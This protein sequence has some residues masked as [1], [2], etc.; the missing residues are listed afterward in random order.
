MGGIFKDPDFITKLAKNPKTAPFLAD[1]EFMEKLN[2]IRQNPNLLQTEL[3]DPRIMQV[4]AALLG[5]QMEMGDPGNSGPGGSGAGGSRF[6]EDTEMPDADPQPKKSSPEPPK[7]PEPADEEAKAKREAKEAADREKALGTENYKKRQFD[8]AIEHYSKA[9]E[10][11]KDITYL[12][13]LAAA[14]F[15]SGDYEGCIQECERAIEEGRE[16]RADF[17]LIA[18]YPSLPPPL[19]ISQPQLT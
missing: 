16:I 10:L 17:K 5:I 2:K 18:K 6:D 9:W 11:Y 3:R 14:K 7:E 19:P 1:S 13:N 15:E 8:Q 4:I 12:N